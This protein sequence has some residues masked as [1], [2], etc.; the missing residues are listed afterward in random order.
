VHAYPGQLAP[1]AQ[2][3]DRLDAGEHRRPVLDC[4]PREHHREPGV[5]HLRVVVADRAGEDVRP[6][7]RRELQRAAP[8]QVPVH[9]QR[10]RAADAVVQRHAGPDVRA[11]PH[12][13]RQ[14]V[15]ERHGPYE[16][17]RQPVQQQ[18]AFLERLTHEREVT[19]LQVTQPAVHQL[20]RPARRA[21]RPVPRL[22]QRDR[23]ATRRRVE[24]GA[25][26]HHA[27]AHD[28]HVELG[29]AKHT[30]CGGPVCEIQPCGHPDPSPLSTKRRR[31]PSRTTW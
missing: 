2:D 6:Q 16:V 17:W 11:L 4:G 1:V 25:G 5:V 28:E 20:A 8:G 19:L 7:R 12:A 18:A 22:D 29:L 26:A 27:T 14:R 10:T 21:R 3:L 9:R 24:C 23:E 13:V 31:R 15:Q 30:Q